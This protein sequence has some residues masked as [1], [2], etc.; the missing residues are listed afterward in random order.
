MRVDALL[1]FRP[2]VQVAV[3]SIGLSVGVIAKS[4]DLDSENF[5]H[6]VTKFNSLD[7]GQAD[8]FIPNANAWKWMVANAPLFN[9]PDK[10]LEETYYF[11]WWTYRKHI[12][13]TPAGFVLTELITPVKHA[14]TFNTISCA[15]GHHLREGRWLR[16]AQ[17]KSGAR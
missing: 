10:Q 3:L 4:A 6:Y 13:Q 7:E 8:N 1:P 12:K 5:A 2:L 14:G 16:D 9:C 11:R 15:A 17:R